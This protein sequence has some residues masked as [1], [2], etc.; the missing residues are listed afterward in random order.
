MVRR[1]L[2]LDVMGWILYLMIVGVFPI[3]PRVSISV[4][5]E[6]SQNLVSFC[7]SEPVGIYDV[8]R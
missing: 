7:F 8:F 2:S 6:M 5:N 1:N 4:K 3:G